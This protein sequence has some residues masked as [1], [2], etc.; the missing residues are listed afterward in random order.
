MKIS[1]TL[2][3]LF[4]ALSFQSNAQPFAIGHTTITFNDPD[5]SNRSIQTEIY[6][7]AISNGENVPVTGN[8]PYPVIVFGHG[9]VMVW[10][11]YQNIWEGLVPNGYI[12]L[13]PRTEGNIFPS[14]T[15]FA[16]DLAFLVTAM[17][18]LN[19]Q[20]G[21]LFLGKV[22]NK[23]AVMGHSM[24]GGS[25]FLSAQYN[26]NI[27]VFAALAPAETNPSAITA[28]AAINR[29]T[30]LIAGTNDCVV[31]T[32]TNAQ[33]MYNALNASCKSLVNL[34]GA[35]HCQFA[36]SNF[37]C[38]LG[39]SCSAT[40]NR[41]TQ[42]NRV[43][44][45]LLPW[46]NYYLKNTC[47]QWNTYMA[48]LNNPANQ[49]TYSQTCP[50]S[51]LCGIPTGLNTININATNATVQW[52]AVNCALK[53]KIRYRKTG[54]TTWLSK[55]SALNSRTLTNLMPASTYEWQVNAVCKLTGATSSGWSPQS[56]FTT[57]SQLLPEAEIIREDDIFIIYPNPVLTECS[58]EFNRDII[59][60]STLLIYNMSGALIKNIVLNNA[61]SE[62]DVFNLSLEQLEAGAYIVAITKADGS[63]FQQKLIKY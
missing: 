13:F 5:R 39:E 38:N 31:P 47:S 32:S 36:E 14:H 40:I 11:A 24:G 17:Q 15:E 59:G 49:L 55:S 44:R 62:G 23:S 10:S 33:L 28:C 58:I 18:T 29:P 3:L 45:I 8:Q 22:T 7:P 53:Y 56:N 20:P 1:A 4:T 51:V 50:T 27:S 42:H 60:E 2:L 41:D 63:N 61:Y 43:N 34:T 21:S 25:T 52:N 48:T 19:T 57:T 12:A 35:N 9:F 46:L 30:L 54:T 16:K 26:P 6:Y 37:N